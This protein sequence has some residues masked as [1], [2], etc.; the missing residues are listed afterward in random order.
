[1]LRLRHLRH[2]CR[3]PA[4]LP[5][6]LAA[7]LPSDLALPPA[8]RRARAAPRPAH[9]RCRFEP[10]AAIRP[11][12]SRP[13]ARRRRVSTIHESSCACPLVLLSSAGFAA[14]RLAR[15]RPPWPTDRVRCERRVGNVPI[16]PKVPDRAPVARGALRPTLTAEPEFTRTR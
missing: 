12:C 15:S 16:K 9:L 14:R 1:P 13:R 4:S 11:G 10:V 3:L 2:L 7:L 5:S 8:R 6:R